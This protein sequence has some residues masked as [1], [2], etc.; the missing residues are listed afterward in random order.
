MLKIDST[1]RISKSSVVQYGQEQGF[2][3]KTNKSLILEFVKP[4]FVK[5]VKSFYSTRI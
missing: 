3:E 1:E 4:L 5:P 2:S